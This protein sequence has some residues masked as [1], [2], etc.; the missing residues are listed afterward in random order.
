MTN[1]LGRLTASFSSPCS[2]VKLLNDIT[3]PKIC[4]RKLGSLSSREMEGGDDRF[5][6]P[7]ERISRENVDRNK[8]DSNV[9]ISHNSV[10]YCCS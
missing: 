6:K 8:A 9:S 5:T 3:P 4:Q 2:R 1:N 7:K 10:F